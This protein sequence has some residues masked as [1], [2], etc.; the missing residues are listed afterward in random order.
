MCIRDRAS[1]GALGGLIG[2][3][4]G[5]RTGGEGAEHRV[6][7]RV[8]PVGVGDGGVGGGF[9]DLGAPGVDGLHE[10]VAD[11][12]LELLVGGGRS[13]IDFVVELVPPV[14]RGLRAGVC[15]LYT[16]IGMKCSRSSGW[17]GPNKHQR[18]R[19]GRWVSSAGKGCCLSDI[20]IS[21]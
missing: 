7:E 9:H 20:K 12:V 2:R 10:Q 4:F 16:S 8:I 11:N 15:L 13:G 6:G 21:H 3:C 17:K 18:K 1:P 19:T 5:A 14:V